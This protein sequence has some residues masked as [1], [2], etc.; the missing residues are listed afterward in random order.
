MSL[1]VSVKNLLRFLDDQSPIGPHHILG[2]EGIILGEGVGI[3]LLAR[4]VEDLA[5]G[6]R[7]RFAGRIVA[8]NGCQKSL[9]VEQTR[10]WTW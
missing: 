2:T 7:Y 9:E 5:G 3:D 1:V 6:E 8:G 10:A 4:F